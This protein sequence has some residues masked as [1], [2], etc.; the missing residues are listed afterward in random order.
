M[1]IRCKACDAAMLTT[2][3]GEEDELEEL[4]QDCLDAI[5]RA[6]YSEFSIYY[7]ESKDFIEYLEQTIDF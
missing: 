7:H 4:C 2:H 1:E 5:D 6:N 3:H